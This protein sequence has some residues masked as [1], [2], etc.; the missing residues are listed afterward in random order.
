MWKL[1]DSLSS[2]AGTAHVA[3]NSDDGEYRIWVEG[4]PETEYFTD[5]FDDAIGAAEHMLKEVLQN[6]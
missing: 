4:Y 1:L 5:N 3:K 2:T 6:G